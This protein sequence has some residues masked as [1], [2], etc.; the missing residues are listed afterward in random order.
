MPPSSQRLISEYIRCLTWFATRKNILESSLGRKSVC[1]RLGV[2]VKQHEPNRTVYPPSL[3]SKQKRAGLQI[4]L[5]RH[6][7]ECREDIQ[8]SKGYILLLPI[9]LHFLLVCVSL[10]ISAWPDVSKKSVLLGVRNDFK[11]WLDSVPRGVLQRKDTHNREERPKLLVVLARLRRRT[12]CGS[13]CCAIV[14][15][16]CRLQWRRFGSPIAPIAEAN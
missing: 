10:K 6:L 15:S 9:P 8:F 5:F 4:R 7:W 12:G 11:F 13:C 14:L 3:N 16:R 1:S 2:L